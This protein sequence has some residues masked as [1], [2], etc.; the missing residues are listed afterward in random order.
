[1][2][3]KI[4][5]HDLVR[6]KAAGA[7]KLPELGTPLANLDAATLEW[8]ALY[9]PDLTAAERDLLFE[10]CDV[11][12]YWEDGKRH[13]AGGLPAIESADGTKEY[14]ERGKRH[15]A[16]GLPA[17]EWADGTKQYYENGK[18]HRA[19]G[20]PAIEYADGTKQYWEHGRR[21]A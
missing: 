3:R 9:I 20:L 16:G 14:W 19:G 15:R 5:Q 8:A 21:V 17:I 12:S 7:C 4:T 13:R 1:M 18:R 10:L 6:A 11:R 2:T